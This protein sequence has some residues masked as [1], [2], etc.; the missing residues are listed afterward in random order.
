MWEAFKS[1]PAACVAVISV[2]LLIPVAAFATLGEDVSSVHSDQVHSN[3]QLRIVPGQAYSVHELHTAAGTIIK[4]FVAANGIV[5]GVS[6]QGPF[7]PDLRQLLGHHFDEYMQASQPAT[8][9]S[10]RGT[11]IETNDL[12]VEATGHMRFKTGRAY[13]RS[14]LPS[15]V[16]PDALQ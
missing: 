6:W 4:E 12:V 15:G 7:T 14:Q 16:S 5:F 8:P 11:H 9:R 2:L 1:R 10:A 3:A 13:L